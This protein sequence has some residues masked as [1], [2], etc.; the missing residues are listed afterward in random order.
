MLE[1]RCGQ[2]FFDF[3]ILGFRFLLL[4]LAIANEINNDIHL[5][6]TLF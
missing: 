3:V 4:E 5:A 1:S 6:N 2:E